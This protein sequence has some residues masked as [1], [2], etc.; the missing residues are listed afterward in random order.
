LG[1]LAVVRRSAKFMA[2]RQ[3]Q[4]ADIATPILDAYVA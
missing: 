1:K 4:Q 2:V 3:A